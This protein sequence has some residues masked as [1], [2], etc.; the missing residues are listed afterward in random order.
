MSSN[1]N[2]FFHPMMLNQAQKRT[3]WCLV[4]DGMFTVFMVE[5]PVSHE[6]GHLKKLIRI[7]D[8]NSVA[9]DD[10][11]AAG[12]NSTSQ[13]SK[14]PCWSYYN[15]FQKS[16]PNMYKQPFFSRQAA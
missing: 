16:W 9:A 1:L 15:C 11:L 8:L 2:I 12:S 14:K 7:P 5:V 6:I 4:D 10:I 13:T 3:L